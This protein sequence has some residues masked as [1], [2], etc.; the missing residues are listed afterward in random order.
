LNAT[1][2]LMYERRVNLYEDRLRSA[3]RNQ[4]G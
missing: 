4:S 2:K 1:P 3:S